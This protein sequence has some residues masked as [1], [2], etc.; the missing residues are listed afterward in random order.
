MSEVKVENAV[1][2]AVQEENSVMNDGDDLP[3]EQMTDGCNVTKV[4]AMNAM[5]VCDDIIGILACVL[6]NETRLSKFCTVFA[7]D[8]GCNDASMIVK[9]PAVDFAKNA[10]YGEYD[11]LS[12]EEYASKLAKIEH[13][14]RY[15]QGKTNVKIDVTEEY[16]EL[17]KR[18]SEDIAL[19]R[20]IRKAAAVVSILDEIDDV[21]A[22]DCPEVKLD[23]NIGDDVND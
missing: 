7:D 8:N 13:L 21:L 3:Y 14:S 5:H 10:E 22:V 23:V 12:D 11:A 20:K 9:N 4:F 6:K 16:V 19:L 18:I 2:Q 17:L 1:E 15:F